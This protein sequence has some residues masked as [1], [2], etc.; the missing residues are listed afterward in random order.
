[1][2][3]NENSKKSEI[4]LKLEEAKQKAQNKILK[5]QF[6][7]TLISILAFI[8][9][10]AFSILRKKYVN[11]SFHIV[12]IVFLVIYIIVF[13]ALISY[14]LVNKNYDKSHLKNFK[15][16]GSTFKTILAIFNK[17]AMIINL[18]GALS[19]SIT[20]YQAIKISGEKPGFLFILTIVVSIFT[21]LSSFLFIL[22][23]I[24][25]LYKKNKKLKKE[26]KNIQ[27]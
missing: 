1:M 18:I 8:F 26:N 14:L 2:E 17:S 10:T 5:A 15:L 21:L 27:K 16:A 23:K 4:S 11:K 3:K 22:R 25:K 13:I 12:A 24:R 9:I 20:Q 19:I 7:Y 6:I